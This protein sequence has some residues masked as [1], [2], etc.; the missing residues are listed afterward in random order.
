MWSQAEDRYSISRIHKRSYK[1]II[2]FNVY[3]LTN[4]LNQVPN[5]GISFTV[6]NVRVKVLHVISFYIYFISFTSLALCNH[7]SR[8]W[9]ARAEKV[10]YISKEYFF[11]YLTKTGGEIVCS[12]SVGFLQ[13]CFDETYK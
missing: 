13:M 3:E 4:S 7:I 5:R 2:C 9:L 6:F 1:H 8:Y 10:V 11:P 12:N